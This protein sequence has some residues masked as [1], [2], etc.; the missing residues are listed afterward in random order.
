MSIDYYN[1]HATQFFSNTVSASMQA[2]YDRV[3]PLLPAGGSILDAGC[4]SG[5]DSHYFLSQGYAVQAMDGSAAMASLASDMTGLVVTHCLFDEYEASCQLDGIWACASLLHVPYTAL[6]GTLAH[7]IQC[8]KPNGIFYLSFKHGATER[9]HEGR[10]FTDINSE[11]LA[12]LVADLPVTLNQ[13]WISMDVRP[14]KA[15][16]RWYNAILQKR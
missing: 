14:D 11:R 4:G 9:E 16:E 15:N 5:R 12:L 2:T 1:A 3:L 13:E 10:H 6:P 7:L 8:L